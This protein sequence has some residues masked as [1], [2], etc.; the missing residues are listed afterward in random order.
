MTFVEAL[1]QFLDARDT[2][3]RLANDRSDWASNER[4]H[5]YAAMQEA[6][7]CMDALAPQPERV[8]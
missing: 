3:G 5:A 6:A 7:D 2:I 1:E 4:K 8:A